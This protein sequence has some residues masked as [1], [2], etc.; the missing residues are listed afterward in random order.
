MLK[1]SFAALIAAAL[2]VTPLAAQ[3]PAAGAPSAATPSAAAQ[4]SAAQAI[5]ELKSALRNMVVAQ[6]RYWAE[7]GTYTTDLS[8]LGLYPAPAGARP[9]AL[10]QVIFAGGRGWSGI[11]V[12]RSLNRS[13]VIFVG[14]PDELPFIPRTTRSRVLAAN[15][16]EPACER[17]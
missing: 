1:H 6:E 13:C 17:P 10:P 15:Q 4:D 8:A 11:A 16:G 2:L 3:Q 12:H 7:H 14:S 9:A 5:A